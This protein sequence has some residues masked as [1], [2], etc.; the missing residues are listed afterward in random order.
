MIEF[1]PA[2]NR[3]E[4]AGRLIWFGAWLLASVL[5][6]F[7][8]PSASGH[9]T[10]TQLGLPPCPSAL[11]FNRPCPGCGLTTSIVALLH[12]DFVGS[13]SAHPMGP[14]LYLIWTLTALAAGYGWL[15]LRK[16]D[17]RGKLFDRLAIG[18]VVALLAFGT[19]RFFNTNFGGPL[20]EL[21][22]MKK[23]NP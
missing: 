23:A 22:T 21:K 15:K 5:A 14:L 2:K 12:G 17:L 19:Y 6:I 16:F 1:S 18:L 3:R 13:Y 11:I 8:T 9:G 4:L 20:A 10:H 7:L